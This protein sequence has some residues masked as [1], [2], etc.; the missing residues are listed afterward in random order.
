[1]FKV[2]HK[3]CSLHL[4]TLEDDSAEEGHN[5]M[6]FFSDESTEALDYRSDLQV[7]LI[8]AKYHHLVNE[9]NATIINSETE[10]RK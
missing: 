3:R 9:F 10:M 5:Q 6:S 4:K 8:F 2:K 7:P 1:M